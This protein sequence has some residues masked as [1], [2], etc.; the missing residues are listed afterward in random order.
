MVLS[1]SLVRVCYGCDSEETS[2]AGNGYPNWYLNR[3]TNLVLCQ[4]CYDKHIRFDRYRLHSKDKNPRMIRFRGPQ[5]VV[6]RIARNGICV[7]CGREGYT[8]IHHKQYDDNDPLAHTI[9]LCPS[10]HV[11]EGWKNGNFDKRWERRRAT[12]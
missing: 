4:S 6:D 9:E 7:N 3:P 8:H 5:I 2:L 1:S 11:K 12:K 10:C